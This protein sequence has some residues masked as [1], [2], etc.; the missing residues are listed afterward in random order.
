MPGTFL[1]ALVLRGARIV[2]GEG[3]ALIPGAVR[4]GVGIMGEQR[5]IARRRRLR[6]DIDRAL[7]DQAPRERSIVCTVSV[8][9][10]FG[11][12]RGVN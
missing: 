1:V 7:T 2:W 9:R 10:T 3:L 11:T 12:G 5:D 4:L 6:L 8:V